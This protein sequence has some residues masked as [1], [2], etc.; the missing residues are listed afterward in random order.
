MMWLCMIYA[1]WR[2]L[3]MRLACEVGCSL[4]ALV[5]QGRSLKAGVIHILAVLLIPL[6]QVYAEPLVH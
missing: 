1:A 6:L 4:C 3:C 5:A 2:W